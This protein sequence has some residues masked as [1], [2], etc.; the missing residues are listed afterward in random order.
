MDRAIFG[1][2]PLL[3][4]YMLLLGE[5]YFLQRYC[6]KVFPLYVIGTTLLQ[7]CDCC[8]QPSGKCVTGS[9]TVL[10]TLWKICYKVSQVNANP[11]TNSSEG[12]GTI[13]KWHIF[14][15]ELP[16]PSNPWPEGLDYPPEQLS[17]VIV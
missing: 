14:A 16:I 2:E 4:N 1:N 8:W 11:V 5:L 17:E 9:M 6:T 10:A 15:R 7:M 13:C 3:Y 12:I